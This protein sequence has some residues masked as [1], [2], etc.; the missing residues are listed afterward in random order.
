MTFSALDS[1]L[2]GPTYATAAMA[3]TI[4]TVP[5]LTRLRFMSF[6]PTVDSGKGSQVAPLV[7]APGSHATSAC[8]AQNTSSG[9]A[10]P[11]AR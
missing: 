10:A 3:A 5:E 8:A 7:P 1:A 2:Y 6:L 11:I 4:I 9:K